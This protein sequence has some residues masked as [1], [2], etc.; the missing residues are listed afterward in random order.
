MIAVV[1]CIVTVLVTVLVI[2]ITRAI[3][4]DIVLVPME[5][6]TVVGIAAP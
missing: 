5:I 4:F 6:V 3:H 2:V 1:R